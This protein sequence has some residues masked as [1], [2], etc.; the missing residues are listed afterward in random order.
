MAST[1]VSTSS[2]TS[3]PG[4]LLQV[5]QGLQA[6]ELV[7]NA[8]PVNTAN[9]AFVAKNN[10]TIDTD[11]EAQTMSITATLPIAFAGS[12]NGLTVTAVDYL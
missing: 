5:A 8:D 11:F 2:A 6:A 1:P 12:A 3:L 9:P 10:V 4:Q 7:H